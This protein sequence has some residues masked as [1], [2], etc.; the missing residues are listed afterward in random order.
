MRIENY[1]GPFPYSNGSPPF[2]ENHTYK[3]FFNQNNIDKFVDNYKNQS[4]SFKFTEGSKNNWQYQHPPLYYFLMASIILPFEST[5]LIDKLIILRLIS[6]LFVFLSVYIVLMSFIKYS[7]DYDINSFVCFFVFFPMFF[8]QFARIGNDSLCILLCSIIFYFL[9]KEKNKLNLVSL[10]FIGILSGLGV[11]TKAFFI[12][13][14]L[15]LMLYII[16]VGF[17]SNLSLKKNLTQIIVLLTGFLIF[18]IPWFIF[19]S[20]FNSDLG[21]GIILNKLINMQGN[22]IINNFSLFEFLRGITVPLITFSWAG[23]QSLTRI[24]VYMQLLF[25]IPFFIYILLILTQAVK[26]KLELLNYSSL[27]LIFVFYSSLIWNVA[28]TMLA[29]GIATS[30]GWYLYILLPW[31]LLL[32]CNVSNSNIIKNTIIK[33]ILTIMFWVSIINT[34][35]SIWLH[36]TLYSGVSTKSDSKYFEFNDSLYGL[37]RFTEVLENTSILNNANYGLFMIIIGYLIFIFIFI[38]SRN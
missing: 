37:S 3:E 29:G 33:K 30:P 8:I 19:N 32:F 11:I 9:I 25:L 12:P 36:L 20:K 21:L 26:N 24:S 6:Y 31:F 15:S 17:K 22:E 5:S 10:F 35:F 34:L 7:S 4:F 14:I 38:K 28:I 23:T 27:I 1:S 13:I 16:L 18:A 2:N